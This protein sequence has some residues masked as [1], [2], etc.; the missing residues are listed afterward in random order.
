[1]INQMNIEFLKEKLYEAAFAGK[2]TLES[3]IVTNARHYEALQRAD[4][5]L[6]AALQGLEQG[7]TG[8]FLA[9]DIRR[10]LAYLGEITGAVG[11]EDLLENI[12]SRFCIGK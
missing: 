4:E 12:F 10:A 11:V 5:S 2:T 3:T 6:H 8:D 7:I 9:M 1:A